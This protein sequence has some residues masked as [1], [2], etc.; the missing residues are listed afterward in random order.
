MTHCTHR[1]LS[2]VLERLVSWFMKQ[3][4]A[5][6][7]I[8]Q[9]QLTALFKSRRR[10]HDAILESIRTGYLSQDSSDQKFYLV[11]ESL[12]ELISEITASDHNGNPLSNGSVAKSA[13]NAA[14]VASSDLRLQTLNPSQRV[15]RKIGTARATREACICINKRA[16]ISRRDIHANEVNTNTL[17][18]PNTHNN[19]NNNNNLNIN[20]NTNYSRVRSKPQAKKPSKQ[21][22]AMA[23]AKEL[24]AAKARG[25]TTP[26][27]EP[28]RVVLADET[29]LV[30]AQLM[31][32][33]Y[34]QQLQAY[35]GRW[36]R[37]SNL[38]PRARTTLLRAVEFAQELGVDYAVYVRAQ[39]WAFDEWFGRAP[40]L[41]ELAS[42]NTQVPAKKRVELFQ[43][44]I[45]EGRINRDRGIRRAASAPKVSVEARMDNSERQLRR[46]MKNYGESEEEI[47]FRFAAGTAAN[48]YFDREWLRENST[49]QR[50]RAEGKL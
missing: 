50:L 22:K 5:V 38:S 27:P 16:Y 41:H 39:F 40:K 9:E 47:L 31:A 30:Q 17:T 2:P 21:A 13:E 6:R 20:N 11:T 25:E 23:R 14:V 7:G 43:A 4:P 49:Y 35:N 24:A 46:F 32:S 42:F 28:V 37:P 36:F 19:I 10:S 18:D 44:E 8:R 26:R 34:S 33:E 1:A 3:T 45:R 15:P 29:E 48:L 12:R